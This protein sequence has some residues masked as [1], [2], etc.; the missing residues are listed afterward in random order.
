M[1]VNVLSVVLLNGMVLKCAY[2][3]RQ[4]ARAVAERISTAKALDPSRTVI[5]KA[6]TP[7][8]PID[9]NIGFVPVSSILTVII[10]MVDMEPEQ[11]LPGSVEVV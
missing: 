10:E 6:A 4:E 5:V 11:I 7:G 9:S 3:S 8:G 1:I 2:N